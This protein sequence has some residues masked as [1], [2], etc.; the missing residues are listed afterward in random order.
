MTRMLRVGA[1]QLGPVQKDHTRADV[2]ERLLILLRGAAERGCDMVAF[3]ELALT[4]FFP[5]WYLEDEAAIDA[6][7]EAQMP[8]PVTQPLFDEARRLGVGFTLGYA[9]LLAAADAPDGRKHRYNTQ[10][11]VERDGTVVGRYR[12][13]HIPGHEANEPWRPFQHLE[14]RIS[15][16]RR[17]CGH[18]HVQRPTVARDLSSDG[19]AR[20]RVDHHW[21]QHA[22]LLRTRSRPK[23][24]AAV[25]QRPLFGLRRLSKRHVGGRCG[26]GWN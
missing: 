12:K 10:I 4:T 19:F 1:G 26:Q 2:V 22:D 17:H 25:S 16:L 3:P 5:R 18:G 9:E 6:W 24:I 21:V 14:R 23:R 8:S 15:G 13:V 20:C 7:Y 11:M